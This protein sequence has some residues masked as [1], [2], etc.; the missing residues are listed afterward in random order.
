LARR[1]VESTS[2][3]DVAA[4]KAEGVGAHLAEQAAGI[5]AKIEESKVELSRLH[6]MA[7]THVEDHEARLV[8]IAPEIK[9][10]VDALARRVV[11][12]EA[13]AE[14]AI[15][16]A[17]E[18]VMGLGYQATNMRAEIDEAKKESLRLHKI[19]MSYVEKHE[20]R[21]IAAESVTLWA[22]VKRCFGL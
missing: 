2:K 14:Q 6:G 8:A 15:V 3:A 16:K 12:A 22:L 7:M 17:Q 11:D 19:A 4:A 10:I 5:Y 1:V 9:A 13:K 21:L 20:T 18:V